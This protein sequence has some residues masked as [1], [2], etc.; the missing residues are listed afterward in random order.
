MSGSIVTC[1]TKTAALPL[2]VRLAHPIDS[3]R[4]ARLVFAD[5]DLTRLL[6]IPPFAFTYDGTSISIPSSNFI[7]GD[8]LADFL[9]LL[10]PKTV[11]KL[12]AFDKHTQMFQI[13][14]LAGHTLTFDSILQNLTGLPAVMTGTSSGKS[15]ISFYNT[16]IFVL[17]DILEPQY[18]NGGRLPLLAGFALRPGDDTLVVQPPQSFPVKLNA[19]RL[20]HFT[21]TFVDQNL[22]SLNFLDNTASALLQIEFS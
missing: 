1:F 4:T 20:E 11:V 17:L 8:E 9:R 7:T 3:V 14:V 13:Q 18:F 10:L 19:N 15:N 12:V 6:P 5:V 22:N 21:V 16:N 2:T